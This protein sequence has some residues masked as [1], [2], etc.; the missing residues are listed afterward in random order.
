VWFYLRGEEYSEQID[1]F[2]RSVE[3]RRTDGQNSFASA[4]QTDR[5]VQ[6]ILSAGMPQLAGAAATIGV[7]APRPKG[8]LAR[9]FG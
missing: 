3:A 8:L 4:L 6:M 7:A 2:V 9:L 1:Y 5:V